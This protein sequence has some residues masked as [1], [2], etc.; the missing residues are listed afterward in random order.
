VRYDIRKLQGVTASGYNALFN[1]AASAPF[2]AD[3]TELVRVELTPFGIEIAATREIVAEYAIDLQLAPLSA[4]SPTI[5]TIVPVAAAAVTPG[6]GSTQ[7]LRAVHV[8]FSVRSREADR[9]QDIPTAAAQD[10]YRLGLGPNGGT[11]FARVR[12]FQ[13]DVPLRNHH[14]AN[15]GI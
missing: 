6:F 15:W 5:P 3:R 1:A 13:A 7:L 4:T 9:V 2:E 8:R 14:G 11:P 12:T 10:R